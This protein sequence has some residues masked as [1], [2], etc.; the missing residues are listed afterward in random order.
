LLVKVIA[1]E[2]NKIRLS[3]KAVLRDQKAKAAAKHDQVAHHEQQE[4]K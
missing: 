3:R 1:I 2:G 4:K